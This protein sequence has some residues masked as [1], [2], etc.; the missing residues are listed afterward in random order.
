MS[1]EINELENNPIVQE[2]DQLSDV[3][4][5]L[6]REKMKIM[7]VKG[8]DKNGE[9]E[10][11]EPT[12]ENQDQFMRVDKNGNIFSNLFNNFWKQ[13][14]NP[15]NF[16]FFKVPQLSS[17]NTADKLQQ[18]LISP[19]EEG[20]KLMKQMEVKQTEVKNTDQQKAENEQE[21]KSEKAMEKNTETQTPETRFTPEQIDWKTLSNLGWDQEK[22]EKYK[23]LDPLLKG[24]KT[25][26]LV[27]VSLNLGT[28]ILRTDARLSLQAGED[29]K[30][31]FVMHGVRKEP[32]LKQKF[33]GHEFSEED[34]QNLLTTRNM[35]RAVN[36]TRNGETAPYII[37]LD[38][39]TN[40]VVALKTS[41]IKIDDNIKGVKLTDEQKASLQQGKPVR[42]EGMIS[43]KDTPFDATLQFN[44]E[45]RHLEYIFDNNKVQK[46]SASNQQSQSGEVPLEFRRKKFSDEQY[47]ALSEG[48]TLYV[49]DFVDGKGQR[50][51]GYV[52]FNKEKGN[53]DFSF[54]DK[55]KE[56]A[57]PAETHKT[58]VAV[59]SDGK[60][61]E[62]TKKI[63]EP[64]KS[65]Q[66][67]PASKK[68]QEKQEEVEVTTAP[69][70][71]K[72]RKM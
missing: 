26:R 22:L 49:P 20:N 41:S 29:G 24:Y 1:D 35:G 58:Q 62:A 66:S 44:A 3:L 68:Q 12:K 38:H 11:V 69:A 23:L 64:L 16:Q 30:A 72:G 2:Q 42:L 32:E 36:L 63:K 47:K 37:S 5:V 48:K 61:N 40:E 56:Q 15:T 55:L 71:R 33:F 13:L 70:K 19:T 4:L 59:N 9:L 34:K 7:A 57:K 6:D 53:F 54:P 28:A 52:S 27:G 65:A 31:I 67:A 10:T 45:K 21:K 14:K 18:N 46:Q 60:T 8:I 39:L 43:K 50:Y 17:V 51:P 25:D